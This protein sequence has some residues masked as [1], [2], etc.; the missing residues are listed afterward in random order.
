MKNWLLYFFV[1]LIIEIVLTITIGLSYKN[2]NSSGGM[3]TVLLLIKLVIDSICLLTM[4]YIFIKLAININTLTLIVSN[5]IIH[6]VFVCIL[7]LMFG[8][9]EISLFQYLKKIYENQLSVIIYLPFLLGSLVMAL[10]YK[11]IFS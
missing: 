4:R 8:V 3:I 5:I 10:F 2:T 9:G 7:W 11:R 1:I 6:I